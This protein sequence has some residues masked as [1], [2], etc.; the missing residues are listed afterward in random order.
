V[1][2]A[3]ALSR[4]LPALALRVTEHGCATR[5]PAPTPDVDRGVPESTRIGEMRIVSG[6]QRFWKGVGAAIGVVFALGIAVL[7]VALLVL[8]IVTVVRAI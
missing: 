2:V 6:I 7:A 1:V 4:V 3:T 8:A 5:P